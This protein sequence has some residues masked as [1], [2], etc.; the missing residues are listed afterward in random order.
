VKYN[1][2][3]YLFIY[4]FTYLFL[5]FFI[6]LFLYLFILSFG[7]SPTG[8]TR[9]RIFTHDGSNYADSRKDV[10]LGFVDITVNTTV[11]T[12]RTNDRRVGYPCSRLTAREHG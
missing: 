4:L 5:F 3:I 11:F 1:R 9:R 8:Q 10:F 7:N 12:V 2:F 6:S